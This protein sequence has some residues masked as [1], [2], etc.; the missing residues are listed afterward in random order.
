[1]IECMLMWNSIDP[2]ERATGIKGVRFVMMFTD[3]GLEDDFF[4]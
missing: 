3:A 1:M 4:Q 2:S